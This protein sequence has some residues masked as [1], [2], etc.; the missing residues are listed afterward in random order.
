MIRLARAEDQAAVEACV[1]DAYEKYRPMIN[2]TPGPMLD[3]YA[4]FIAA[5][6]VDVVERPGGTGE[7]EIVGL[8]VS[9]PEPHHDPEH[10]EIET[11][12]VLEKCQ[13]EGIGRLLLALAEERVREHGIQW[14]R[15]YTNEVM[16]DNYAWY[17]RAGFVD[18]ERRNDRGYNRIFFEKQIAPIAVRRVRSGEGA[19]LREIRLRAL[20]D[21][22][23]AF[24]SR[25]EDAVLLT[26]DRWESHITGGGVES[27]RFVA[28]A[29]GRWVGMAGT[30]RSDEG[31]E[32]ISMWVDPTQR[33]SGAGRLLVEAVVRSAQAE[34]IRLWVIRGNEAARS[35]YE[36][37]G[38]AVEDDLTDTDHPCHGE[39]RM[40]HR[41]VA[42]AGE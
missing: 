35:L 4:A 31:I 30:Y 37:C 28:V 36:R 38:F 2:R 1:A 33:G 17:K 27:Q 29:D 32:L 26:E 8:M 39:V 22:P 11:L 15:L 16:T 3:D 14:A 12:A 6:F 42:A 18:Y 7:P 5:G 34:A 9:F 13:G 10:I 41:P 23:S 40:V 19:Q 21:A 24:T 25:Y 20:L